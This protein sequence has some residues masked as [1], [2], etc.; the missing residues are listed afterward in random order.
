VSALGENPFNKEPICRLG[1]RLL[2]LIGGEMAKV[3]QRKSPAKGVSNPLARQKFNSEAQNLLRKIIVLESSDSTAN[4]WIY[5]NDRWKE[6]I[7]ALLTRIAPSLPEVGIR[8]LIDRMHGAG[9]L[10]VKYLARIAALPMKTKLREHQARLIMELLI[11]SAFP[12]EAAKNGLVAVSEAALG[13]QSHF[14]GKVQ[15]YL[16]SYGEIMLADLKK[17]FSFSNL[18]DADVKHSFTYW[19]QN[20]LAMPLPLIDESWQIS[21]RHY[22][23]DPIHLIA[24]ADDVGINLAVLDDLLRSYLAKR[25]VHDARRPAPRL[26]ESQIVGR[27]GGKPGKGRGKRIAAPPA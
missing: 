4:P 23:I 5:E 18:S 21:C 24:A 15:R 9:L 20:V 27:S 8:S 10:D 3:A 25:S 26:N 17:F 14:D 2:S 6:L 7:F 13:L 12:E 19:L 22:E 1:C 16:R 11:E